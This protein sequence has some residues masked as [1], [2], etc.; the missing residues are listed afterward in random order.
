MK[1]TMGKVEE[2]EEAGFE[3][4]LFT[5]YLA[6]CSPV[7]TD[8]LCHARLTTFIAWP[9]RD[10]WNFSPRENDVDASENIRARTTRL[11]RTIP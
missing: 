4:V 5:V 10:A 9:L 11:C 2:E 8:A 3:L 6:R 7:F 1:G